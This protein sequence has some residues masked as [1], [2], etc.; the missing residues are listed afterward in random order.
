MRMSKRQQDYS[1]CGESQSQ[2]R[3]CLVYLCFRPTTA[4]RLSNESTRY[5][6]SH[7][8]TDNIVGAH[9]LITLMLFAFSDA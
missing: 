1:N 3:R 4:K 6:V 2:P 8:F 5:T 7:I 9:S